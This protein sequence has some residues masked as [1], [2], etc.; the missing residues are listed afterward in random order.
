MTPQEHWTLRAFAI[1]IIAACC[2]KCSGSQEIVINVPARPP[3]DGSSHR[4]TAAEEEERRHPT[5]LAPKPELDA[6]L[7]G[8]QWWNR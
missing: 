3:A 4:L 8:W 6:Y 5:P 1:L 2:I 7:Q